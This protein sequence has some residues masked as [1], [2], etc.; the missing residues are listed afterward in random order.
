[1]LNEESLKLH[2]DRMLFD[3]KREVFVEGAEYG[4]E[5]GKKEGMEEGIEEGRMEK[6]IDVAKKALR[7][8]IPIHLISKLTGLDED[9]IKNIENDEVDNDLKNSK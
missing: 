5:K 7:I 9:V 4:I 3:L 1:M 8:D 2:I 6:G